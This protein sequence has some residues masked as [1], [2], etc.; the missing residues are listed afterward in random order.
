MSQTRIGWLL[1][2]GAL[3]QVLTL[4]LAV[5][6]TVKIQQA[7]DRKQCELIAAQVAVYRETPPSTAT[8]QALARSWNAQSRKYGCP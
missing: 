4:A 8:G 6:I 2:C 3:A 5:L 1:M 7:S